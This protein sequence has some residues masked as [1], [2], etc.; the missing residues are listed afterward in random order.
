MATHAGARRPPP[1]E[2]E[3]CVPRDFLAG[4]G[5]GAGSG[6]LD[7]ASSNSETVPYAENDAFLPH[8]SFVP[9]GAESGSASVSHSQ[10]AARSPSSPSSRRRNASAGSGGRRTEF[11]SLFGS[12][13]SR[14]S[15]KRIWLW[16]FELYSFVYTR[17][18]LPVRLYAANRQALLLYV[19]LFFGR[20]VE[21]IFHFTACVVPA[22]FYVFFAM[23]LNL[24]TVAPQT[25]AASH[26]PSP[27]AASSALG[28]SGAESGGLE[29]PAE[30]GAKGAAGAS[31][32]FDL[33][34]ALRSAPGAVRPPTPSGAA[35]GR[36]AP[37]AAAD[38]GRGMLPRVFQR[39]AGAGVV[40]EGG[41]P[42]ASGRLSVPPRSEGL[43]AEE[44]DDAAPRGDAASH[45]VGLGDG[46]GEDGESFFSSIGLAYVYLV[47]SQ[48]CRGLLLE[49]PL[50]TFSLYFAQ[51][52]HLQSLTFSLSP[53]CRQAAEAATAYYGQN[54]R[55]GFAAGTGVEPQRA[56]AEATSQ[57]AVAAAERT[58][59]AAWGDEAE[60]AQTGG[61][62]EGEPEDGGG[63]ESEPEGGGGGESEPEGGG[64]GESEP[65]GGGGGESEPEGEAR[66]LRSLGEPDELALLD[67]AV[68]Q[69]L[70]EIQEEAEA[71]AAEAG[72]DTPPAGEELLTGTRD[73]AGERREGD[74]R[75][76]D[77]D[78]DSRQGG[79]GHA[80]ALLQAGWGE[81]RADEA[82]RNDDDED[83]TSSVVSSF[84]QTPTEGTRNAP[85]SSR[86]L[87]GRAPSSPS[88]SG[89]PSRDT[90]PPPLS[91]SGRGTHTDRRAEGDFPTLV[92]SRRLSPEADVDGAAR[93]ASPSARR[94]PRQAASAQPPYALDSPRGSHPT[95][96]PTHSHRPGDARQ[97]ERRDGRDAQP[98]VLARV[99]SFVRGAVDALQTR[100][101]L[102]RWPPPARAVD[103]GERAAAQP[104]GGAS[105]AA[106][107]SPNAQRF[108]AVR[109]GDGGRRAAEASRRHNRERRMRELAYRER[110]GLRAVVATVRRW[111]EEARMRHSRRRVSFLRR[112]CGPVYRR[113]LSLC[114]WL[115]P[116]GR[117]RF[118]E[119]VRQLHPYRLLSVSPLVFFP[120]ASQRLFFTTFFFWLLRCLYEDQAEEATADE[121]WGFLVNG[122]NLVGVASSFGSYHA[123]RLAS[124]NPGY[125]SAFSAFQ[126]SDTAGGEGGAKA[127]G[128]SLALS[129]PL[130]GHGAVPR[131]PF[132]LAR[133]WTVWWAVVLLGLLLVSYGLLALFSAL[134]VLPWQL[135]HS[136]LVLRHT[137]VATYA[138]QK[139]L[140]AER[141]REKR[142]K[143]L[144]A[145]QAAAA[146]A[147][148]RGEACG[149]GPQRE[150]EEESQRARPRKAGAAGA[151]GEE[152][153]GLR[154]RLPSSPA[155]RAEVGMSLP[156][157][158][159]PLEEEEEDEEEM[160]I[161]C[162]EEF[163]PQ[164]ILRVVN[165]CGHKFHRHCVDVWLF[166][167][168][169]ETCPMCGQLRSP[170]RA[171]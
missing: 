67:A 63:G 155:G 77:D 137:R 64:G 28:L 162:F 144:Q 3:A 72:P 136:L 1:L 159:L 108:S 32:K 15:M 97:G 141:R 94:E 82:G 35:P 37:S 60:E 54:A 113:F 73:E 131:P 17:Y 129:D 132:S 34:G 79:R 40:F 102:R 93:R 88:T 151:S 103:G 100:L 90:S 153:A 53:K 49:V 98:F 27:R 171:K 45:L 87:W 13:Y 152:K 62:A 11:A 25:S 44:R 70:L 160:C 169:K 59:D 154:R 114:W 158:V 57:A 52:L 134:D 2:L 33:A 104:R 121:A 80:P 99:L 150:E 18:V 147:T 128:A 42:A 55:V 126:R 140:E 68:E 89:A 61:R 166:K 86:S 138:E 84:L 76:G 8:A 9:R 163:K 146:N 22:F 111:S 38:E 4:S 156:S 24:I 161:F 96:E 122:G 116:G 21:F 133:Q 71:R 26:S 92:N 7:S 170:R 39:S 41:R 75:E 145:T 143:Q 95:F 101:E 10:V 6:C 168:Q 107:V 56:V 16:A 142:R 50:Y 66:A 78:G 46:S 19:F 115:V 118:R 74:A 110:G 165:C 123:T 130:G 29:G 69:Q 124:L 167:R 125:Y 47:L 117:L 58:T 48:V 149:K 119:L 106:L 135:L 139:K 20:V 157:V 31:A 30:T 164:D 112:I 36:A 83:E 43:R 105:N 81:S 14:F 5:G 127:R 120:T 109:A 85:R 51:L 91:S 65:E 23:F 12:L 148:A